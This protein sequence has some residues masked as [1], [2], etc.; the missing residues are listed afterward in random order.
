MVLAVLI[1]LRVWKYHWAT[2]R[3]TLQVSSNNMAALANT[4]HQYL[5]PVDAVS[6]A[7]DPVICIQRPRAEVV[8]VMAD[9]FRLPE[10][11]GHRMIRAVDGGVVEARMHGDL[12]LSVTPDA[13][14]VDYTWRQGAAAKT[15]RIA[16]EAVQEGTRVSVSLQA[17]AA[18]SRAAV[19]EILSVE[20]RALA[21]VVEG[22]PE[23]ISA[24]DHA[25]LDAWHL[26]LH[27]RR[28]V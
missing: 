18:E 1:P 12:A 5:D 19:S 3:C 2:M 22:Q 13:G 4:M 17:F 23:R 27:Q 9:P 21:A 20:L 26:A 15:V 7:P 6:D 28:G 16:V 10:W 24:A 8:A 11:T 25:R 14:G